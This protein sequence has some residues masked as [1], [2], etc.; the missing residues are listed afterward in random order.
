MSPSLDKGVTAASLPTTQHSFQLD[1]YIRNPC[2]AG[3]A[4]RHPSALQG[5]GDL[6]HANSAPEAPPVYF[7]LQVGYLRKIFKDIE[8]VVQNLSPCS[9]SSACRTSPGIELLLLAFQCQLPL[10]GSSIS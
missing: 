6:G 5:E 10:R 4:S 2:T 9:H 3:H 1:A 7:V 8:L